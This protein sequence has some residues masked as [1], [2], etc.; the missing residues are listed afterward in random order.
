MRGF[1]DGK[2]K[3]SLSLEASVARHDYFLSPSR[4]MRYRDISE[5]LFLTCKSPMHLIRPRCKDVA[6][7]RGSVDTE[8][9]P[10]AD[11]ALELLETSSVTMLQ[12]SQLL[13]SFNTVVLSDCVLTTVS[14]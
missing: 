3:S 10:C 2:A 6:A 1:V 14:Y 12:S 11:I 13:I 4:G 9:I 7:V 8:T 5:F